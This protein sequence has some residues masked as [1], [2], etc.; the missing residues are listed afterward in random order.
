[1]ERA[2]HGDFGLISRAMTCVQRAHS[3]RLCS[4]GH[5]VAFANMPT[6]THA[7]TDL[8]TYSTSLV[9][10]T[11]SRHTPCTLTHASLHHTRQGLSS[12]PQILFFLQSWSCAPRQDRVRQSIVSPICHFPGARTSVLPKSAIVFHQIVSSWRFFAFFRH[13]SPKRAARPYSGPDTRGKQPATSWI[14]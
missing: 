6:P 4:V 9:C 10:D 14:F 12:L 3:H 7:T 13:P 2:G 11:P 5:Q 1:M 8:L